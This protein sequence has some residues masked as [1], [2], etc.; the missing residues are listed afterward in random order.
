M[1]NALLKLKGWMAGRK[2]YLLAGAVCLV[3]GVLVFFHKLTPATALTV[4]LFALGGFAATFRAALQTH[5]D[6]S[7]LVLQDVAAVGAAVATH[8]TAS[9]I[10]PLL[11][12]AA[13]DSYT[14]ASEIQQEAVKQ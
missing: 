5:H 9:T 12:N 14:L 8:H 7:L 3:A 11:L 1:K 2:T 13:K 10:D 6:Q 4:A